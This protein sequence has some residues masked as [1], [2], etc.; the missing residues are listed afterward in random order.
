MEVKASDQKRVLRRGVGAGFGFS[1][2][3]FRQ[4]STQQNHFQFTVHAL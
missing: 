2:E 4:L 3:R 1:I